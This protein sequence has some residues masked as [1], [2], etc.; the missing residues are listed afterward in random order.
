MDER[1]LIVDDEV[2][3][4]DSMVEFV[5]RAGYPVFS[6]GSAEDAVK[7]LRECPMDI[8]IT[9]IILPGMDGLG[10]TDI[11]KT[12]YDTDVIVMTGYSGDY[13]Y[14]EAINKGASDFVFKPVR[15][16]ELLL[17]LRR[18]T[19]E[20]SLTK[21]REKMLGR[22]QNLAITDGL[23]K[24]NNSRHFYTQLAM[25]VQRSNRYGHPLALLLLDIDN[26][27]KF[28]DNYGHLEG[29]RVLVRIAEVIKRC[30]RTMDS[31]YRY[32]GEEFTIL[33]PETN[34]DEALT[35]AERLRNAVEEEKFS[36]DSDEDISV[37]VS[38]GVT[39]YRQNEKQSTFVHRA[40]QAMYQS[41]EN[42]RNSVSL[43]NSDNAA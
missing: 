27:K 42:G 25:E 41:K 13:S 8:V 30:L 26:F 20:R 17:R 6:A 43:L 7:L 32:G 33:L 18:V 22:L 14:E 40:D 37:T 34:A 3:I 15:F 10:L 24:L 23:T 36:P 28:N 19:R 9:D 4:R 2:N 16:E 35:V 21:E 38:V 29:D 31:A 12:D 39:G 11:I 5:E 1:V